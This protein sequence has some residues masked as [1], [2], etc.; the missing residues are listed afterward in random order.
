[1]FHQ[2]QTNPR[3][4]LNLV[5]LRFDFVRKNTSIRIRKKQRDKY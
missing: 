1:M 4:R 2:T 5:N 3:Y